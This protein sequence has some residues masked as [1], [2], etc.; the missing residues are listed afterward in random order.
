MPAASSSR[1]SR[2]WPDGRSRGHWSMRRCSP[3]A[4]RGWR[5]CRRSTRRRR[6][7]PMWCVPARRRCTRCARWGRSRSAGVVG[8]GVGHCRPADHAVARRPGMIGSVLL[9]ARFR[10][11]S[12]PRARSPGDAVDGSLRR[13]RARAPRPGRS[14][15]E[16]A[17]RIQPA[18][19]ASFSRCGRAVAC[20]A[21]VPR[22][23]LAHLP[24]PRRSDALPRKR[25]IV[26]SW[27]DYLR[28]A[29]ARRSPTRRSGR[30]ARSRS[31]ASRWRSQHY[32]AER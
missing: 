9:R 18:D 13:R 5:C 21:S 4:R 27:A 15:V 11:A 2:R 29:S 20:R 12:A 32:I 1:W 19:A 17:Y 26:T 23:V 10:C 28:Y 14:P 31:R 24:R 25:F 8:R 16:I 22:D 7:A 3:A 30:G 6:P